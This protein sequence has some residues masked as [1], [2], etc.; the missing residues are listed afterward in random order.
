M[1]TSSSIKP[2]YVV[3]FAGHR[4]AESPGRSSDDIKATIPIIS[5][6]LKALQEQVSPQSGVIHL[7]TSIAEGSDLAAIE[8]AQ[9]LDITTHIL[10]P[11]PEELYKHDFSDNPDKWQQISQILSHAR[12]SSTSS[13]VRVADASHLRPDCYADTNEQIINSSDALIAVW[14]KKDER[15]TGGTA[16]VWRDAESKCLPRI[17]IN[18]LTKESHE[19]DLAKLQKEADQA[20]IALYNL[21]DELPSPP[22]QKD[23]STGSYVEQC[24]HALDQRAKEHSKS[25]RSGLLRAIWLHGSASILAAIGVSYA[26]AHGSQAISIL[27]TVSIL[28]FFLILYAEILHHKQHKGHVGEHWINCR[29]AA[30]LLRPFHLT[31]SIL[32]PLIYPIQRQYPKWR[33]FLISIHFSEAPVRTADLNTAKQIYASRRIDE[34]LEHFR[35]RQ[36][37]AAPKSTRIYR[38]I[39]GFSYSA[40]LVVF[41]AAIYKVSHLNWSG[42]VSHAEP[43]YAP[44]F[45]FL[46]FLLY[47]LPIALPLLAGILLALRQSLDLSRRHLRYGQMIEYLER[48]QKSVEN[49]YTQHN[50]QSIV[51]ETEDALLDELKEFNIAQRIGLE[52]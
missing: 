21:I 7:F 46:E 51:R 12:D 8:A 26:L 2:V 3:A 18:P 44:S 17:H 38:C 11:L 28:E 49:T 40:L 32:D 37:Q 25:A 24:F 20:G 13:T 39:R 23:N 22:T 10:L 45:N 35:T 1:L 42:D 33:R 4:T 16:Q 52:H 15:G 30:E 41:C 6:S 14:D 43:H 29:F 9:D 50:F 34:Q 5:E 31:R 47:L 36:Q 19:Y 27:C 48:A